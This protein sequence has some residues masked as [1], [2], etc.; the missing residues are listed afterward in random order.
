VEKVKIDL[1]N[2]T[3]DFVAP[4][5][6]QPE[7]DHAMLTSNSTTGN[8]WNEFWRDAR[9]N[10]YFSYLLS[11][12]GETALSLMIRYWGAEWGNRKFEIWIDEEK[13]ISEDN[14]GR[15]NQSRFHNVDYTIPEHMVRDK[16]NIRVKFQSVPGSTAG[17]VYYIRLLRKGE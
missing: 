16:K 12:G 3:V 6:Q 13:L 10:G 14:T 17:A 7:A 8:H 9:N 15:W 4:G 5:E 1:Q 2:R 11:T